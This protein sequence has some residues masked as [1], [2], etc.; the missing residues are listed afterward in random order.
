[1]GHRIWVDDLS[2]RA[3]GSAA[4]VTSDLIRCLRDTCRGLAQLHLRV[5]QKSV[6]M[7]SAFKEAVKV[8]RAL[9]R[10][11]FTVKAQRTA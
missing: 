11:G 9:R 10:A 1:M 4:S 2:Q 7:C 6:V 8:S 5:A 3:V